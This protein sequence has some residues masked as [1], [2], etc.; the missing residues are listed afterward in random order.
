MNKESLIEKIKK[1]LALATDNS[2]TEHEKS[3]AMNRAQELMAEYSIEECDLKFTRAE[4]LILKEEFVLNLEDHMPT[5]L[6][7]PMFRG[8]ILAPICQNFGCYVYQVGLGPIGKQY[9]MG[10]KTNIEVAKYACDVLINQGVKDF[11]IGFQ[12]HRSIAY[13]IN[14]WGGFRAGLIARFSKLSNEKAI[15]LYDKL[16]A[17]LIKEVQFVKMAPP[18]STYAGGT[19]EGFKSAI[20]AKLNPAVSTSKEGLLK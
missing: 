11:K 19:Q 1:L 3:S 5:M 20:D 8:N 15:I 12:E 16:K 18:I 9:I 7:D 13:G 2:T 4:D 14:F 6:Q 10:F 17:Q